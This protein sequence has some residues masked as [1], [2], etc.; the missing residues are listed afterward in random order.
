MAPT[1]LA[2][3]NP[4][5]DKRPHSTGHSYGCASARCPDPEAM[6]EAVENLREAGVFVNVAAGNS[7]PGCS[8][9]SKKQKMITI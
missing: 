3:N 7:G 9:Y 8:T 5:P 6:K 2:G 4:D 1:D